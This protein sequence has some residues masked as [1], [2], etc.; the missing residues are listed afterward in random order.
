MTTDHVLVL[1]ASTESLLSGPIGVF[2][3]YP[4]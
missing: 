1:L 3:R 4:L 2:G